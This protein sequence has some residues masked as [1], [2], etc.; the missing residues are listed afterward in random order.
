MSFPTNVWGSS[1]FP[2]TGNGFPVKRNK[3]TDAIILA[4]FSNNEHGAYYDPYDLTDEKLAWRRNLLDW[5]EAFGNSKWAKFN[6]SVS[7]NLLSRTSTSAASYIQQTG[8]GFNINDKTV[9]Y[10]VECAVGTVGTRLGIRLQPRYTRRLD[11]VI[12]LSTGVIVGLHNAEGA[13]S[14]IITQISTLANGRVRLRVTATYTGEETN[15]TFIMGPANPT[16]IGAWEG[17]SP[18]LTNA[19]VYQIQIERGSLATSYQK[20]TNFHSDF[21]QAFPNHTL[22]QDSL[23]AIP[24]TRHMQPVG[25]VLDKKLDGVRGEN[26]NRELLISNYSTLGSGA[27]TL[28]QDVGGLT[29]TNTQTGSLVVFDSSTPLSINTAYEVVVT[30]DAMNDS[31]TINLPSQSESNVPLVLGQNTAVVK[32]THPN[33]TVFRVG[34]TGDRPANSSITISQFTVRPILG[35]HAIQSV[36][37]ARPLWQNNNGIKTFYRDGVDD[38]LNVTLPAATYTRIVANTGTGYATNTVVHGGGALNILGSGQGNSAG[39]I[40]I[41]R[42]L[43]PIEAANVETLFNQRAGA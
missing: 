31:F 18:E 25:L 3:L 15:F 8:I 43:T 16:S 30:V 7:G 41:D 21:M 1:G 4:L 5:S 33:A 34:N 32:T 19:N 37:A 12:N 20:I 23:G 42:V 13:W 27:P 9:T 14:N 24:V 6:I 29:L 2:F 35:N 17:G 36:S 10:T 39:Y 22:F 11:V 38:A 28:T 40:L 26:Q